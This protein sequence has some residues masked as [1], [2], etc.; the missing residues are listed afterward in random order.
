MTAATVPPELVRV[1]DV[2]AADFSGV[3]ATETVTECVP[4]SHARLLPA[5][6]TAYLPLFAHRFARERLRAS[7]LADGRIT[8]EVPLVLFVCTHNAGRSQMAA[9]LLGQSA[10]GRVEI[11]S[12]GTAPAGE[13]DPM[14]AA[15]LAEVRVDTA[16]AFPKPLTDEVVRAADVVVTMGCGDACPVVPG[17]RYLDWDLPDPLG[18]DLTTVRAIRA[19]IQARVHA[20][21]A[22]VA[23]QPAQARP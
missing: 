21:L 17:R 15:A 22:E 1:V 6:V 19:D 11:T 20:L 3:F 10:G 13:L 7:G 9:G 16:G 5:E 4:D 18:A 2:L 14:V 12:A 8:R 23:P